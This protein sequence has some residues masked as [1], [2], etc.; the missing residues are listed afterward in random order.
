MTNDQLIYET[1][2]RAGFTP[3]AAKLVVAQA[4]FESADYTSSVFKNNNNTSGM[5]FIGQPLANERT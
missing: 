2:I 1:A 3:T 5:K 4:R